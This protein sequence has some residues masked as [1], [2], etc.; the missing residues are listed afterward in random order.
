LFITS[1]VAGY[2]F[3][4]SPWRRA[5][6]TC[7]VIPLAI[8]RNGFRIFTIA[9]LCV[10]VSPDMIN[11]PIHRRGGPIFFV[12]SLIP[13]FLLLVWLRRRE[14]RAVRSAGSGAELAAHSP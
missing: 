8:L 13:F 7:F 10:H 1:L 14:R 4:K 9:M 12:L 3:F 2:L 6:L 11:S 5:V